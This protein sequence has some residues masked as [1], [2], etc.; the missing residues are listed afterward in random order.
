VALHEEEVHGSGYAQPITLKPVVEKWKA[1]CHCRS[2]ENRE[3][4]REG[5]KVFGGSRVAQQ[6]EVSG[7]LSY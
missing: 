6:E 3:G 2:S 5:F 7:L 4:G 1:K